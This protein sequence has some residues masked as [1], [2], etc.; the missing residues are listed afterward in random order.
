MRK[1]RFSLYFFLLFLIVHTGCAR[2]T[3]ANLDSGG[4]AIICFGDSLTA[5]EGATAGHDYPSRLSELL[6]REVIN[7]GVGGDTTESALKRLES[8]VLRRDPLLVIVL[9]GGNDF[10]QKASREATFRN[11][12]EMVHRIESH[13]AMVVLVGVQAGLFGD[14]YRSDYKQVAQKYHADFIP[15][16]LQGIFTDARLKS[17]E[18]H[19]N[20]AGYERMAQRIYKTV[21]PLLEKNAK[22]RKETE[23]STF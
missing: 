23:T 13:G 21:S 12:E 11:L 14:A 19:P 7:A 3:L 8:D 1:S 10:L 16:I 5:G 15:N 22:L 2:P 17:D 6:G 20:D 9:L 18:I 4:S